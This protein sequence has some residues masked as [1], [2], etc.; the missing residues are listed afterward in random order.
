W[1][2]ERKLFLQK[3]HDL[4][5]ARRVHDARFDERGRVFEAGVFGHVEIFDD[6]RA[7]RVLDVHGC[8]L[9]ASPCLLIF[10]VVVFGRA[11]TKTT[12]LGTMKDSSRRMHSRSM[13]FASIDAPRS[14]TTNAFTACPR[15]ASGTPMTAASFTPWM[16]TM[17]FSTSLG[18]TFSPRDLMTSSMRPTKWR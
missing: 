7:N 3:C 1:D 15:S 9:H 12:C 18:A 14:S 10:P 8:L 5:H 16:S 4:Q 11:S 17:A 13:S 6:E 2:R